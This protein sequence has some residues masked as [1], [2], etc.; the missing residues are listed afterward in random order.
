[1]LG[2]EVIQPV[3]LIFGADTNSEKLTEPEFLM[4]LRA[5][6]QM[7]HRKAR[8]KIQSSQEYQKR[9][10]DHQLLQHVYEEGDIVLKLNKATKTGHSSKLQPV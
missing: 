1:M 7:V 10:Y 9:Y 6:L 8:E 3:D 4:D 5:R 2:R